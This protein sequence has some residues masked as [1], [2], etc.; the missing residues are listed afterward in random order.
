[1]E[2]KVK[3]KK[4]MK[5]STKV[6][7]FIVIVVFAVVSVLIAVSYFESQN[8]MYAMV[9]D[10]CVDGTG[11]LELYLEGVEDL[12]AEDRTAVLDSLKAKTGYEY[13]IFSGDTRAFTTIVVDGERVTGTQLDPEIANV[14]ISQGVPYL[15]QAVILGENHL[16]SYIPYKN[17]TGEVIGVLFSGVSTAVVLDDLMSV[18]TTNAVLATV[19]IIFS[20]IL[21]NVFVKKVITSRLSK[22][23]VAADFV[24]NGN[25]DFEL[26]E[27]SNDEIGLLT[28]SFIAMK[29]NLTKINIDMV[30]SLSKLAGGDW[31]VKM[32]NEDLY[33]GQ[34]HGLYASIKKMIDS[35]YN[36]LTQVADSSG[37]ILVGAQQV[38]QGAQV[39]AEGSIDQSNEIEKLS[40]SISNISVNVRSNFD[41]AEKANELAVNSGEV[42]KI[43]MEEM[44]ELKVAMDEIFKTFDD[45]SKII[46]VIDDI[47]FQTNILALNAAVEAAR[48]GAAGSGFAVVADEVRNLAQR[49]A[50]AARDTTDLINKSV[51]TV[52]G[53]VQIMN[54][55]SVSFEELAEKVNA[56]VV[57]IDEIS[58]SCREQTASIG[59]TT[60]EIEQISAVV[61]TNSATSE[62]SAAASE[63]LSG[64]AGLLNE[65]M[66]EFKF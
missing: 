49:S 29:S 15:G 2:N 35:V 24:A 42:T 1:M 36:A 45:I 34:W 16:C 46:K 41:N 11:V 55:T 22:V 58:N 39:L 65:I 13:T 48:A 9:E 3:T 59:S 50:D 26:Q 25:Y 40:N 8:S 32:K 18:A 6:N 28:D 20:A 54:R 63:E 31:T 23:V 66:S 62:E 30:D 14:V 51:S 19:I 52:N 33:I 47:A 53:G 64:Q 4:S 21:A 5:L 10:Q 37:Q 60:N 57:V 38:S 17:S 12:L 27:T 61:H 43:T 7:L 44:T 56:M